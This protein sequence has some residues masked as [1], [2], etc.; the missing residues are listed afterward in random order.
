MTAK[1]VAVVRSYPPTLGNPA[2]GNLLFA[3][4]AREQEDY[5]S[6]SFDTISSSGPNAAVI[7]Y[8]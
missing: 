6:L 8:K 4:I 3:Y 2:C 7:H 5:V 1:L